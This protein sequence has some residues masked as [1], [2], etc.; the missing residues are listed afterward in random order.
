MPNRRQHP[1]I[2][3]AIGVRKAARQIEA[4]L[5]RQPLYGPP[6][7]VPPYA[8]ARDSPAPAPAS[9]S[10]PRRTNT[11]RIRQQVVSRGTPSQ[12]FPQLLRRALREQLERS[13][14]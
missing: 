7:P 14:D 3:R 11:N 4:M 8:L 9:F 6:L 12:L 13:T 10:K 1:A 2:A 5:A